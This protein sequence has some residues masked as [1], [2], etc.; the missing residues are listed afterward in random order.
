MA[1]A[2]KKPDMVAAA[3]RVSTSGEAA[4][5]LAVAQRCYDERDF[6][7]LPVLADALEEAGCDNEELLRHLRGWEM[8]GCEMERVYG[9]PAPRPAAGGQML[10]CMRCDDGWVRLRGPHVRGCWAVDLV[11][12]KE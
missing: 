12:G 6:A 10:T 7:G 4:L 2:K 1:E 9:V 3:A 5:A 8:C 11:L